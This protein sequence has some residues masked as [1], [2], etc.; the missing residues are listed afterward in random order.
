[1]PARISGVS[2]RLLECAKE[3]F[4]LKGFQNASIRTIAKKADTSARAVYTR[5]PDKEGL[6]LLMESENL[7]LR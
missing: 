5:F 6:F 7:I 4:L 1:M 3:E 2:A